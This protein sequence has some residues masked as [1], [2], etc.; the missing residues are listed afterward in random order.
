[1]S[2]KTPD[3]SI[4]IPCFNE[5]GAISQ[6]GERIAELREHL[7]WS[8]ELVLIDDGSG[9]NTWLEIQK[10]QQRYDFVAPV[11]HPENR[12]I[13]AGWHTGFAAAKGRYVVTM[14]ADLQYRPEDII[15]LKRKLDETGAEVVQGA[16]VKELERSALRRL[17]TA[18]LSWLLNLMF[19]MKLVDNKSGFILCRREVFG[20]ILTTRYQYRHFQHFIA[21]SAHAKGYRIVQV[22][23]VFDPRVAGQSFMRHPVHFAFTAIADLPWALWEFRFRRRKAVN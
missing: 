19:G 6:L 17:M 1:M 5:E 2:D 13:V 14:D 23:V 20:D 12:G 4:I 18:G 8:Y 9:D 11:Q 15:A 16:R 22:P 21:V 3:L 7:D 10:L